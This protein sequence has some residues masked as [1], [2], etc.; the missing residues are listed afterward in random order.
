MKSKDAIQIE[1]SSAMKNA[2]KLKRCADQLQMIHR[3]MDRLTDELQ[4]A[5]EGDSARICVAKCHEFSEKMNKS[6]ANLEQ[7]ANV[8]QRTAKAYRTAELAAIKL[9]QQ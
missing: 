5:W 7:I 9:A 2:E 6:E 1:Y 3:S 4:N 8:I